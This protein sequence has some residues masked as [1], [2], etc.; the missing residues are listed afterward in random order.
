[1]SVCMSSVSAGISEVLIKYT[2][3]Y[4]KIYFIMKITYLLFL[5]ILFLIILWVLQGYSFL[6]GLLTGREV[7][8]PAG[9][10]FSSS[11]WTLSTADLVPRPLVPYFFL[12][13]RHSVAWPC[14]PRS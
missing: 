14:L 7:W 5:I 6:W 12:N 4:V 11:V 9:L 2:G 10:F 8:V 3:K 13:D 1:M